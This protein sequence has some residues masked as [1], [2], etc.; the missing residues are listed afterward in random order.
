MKH[1][2]LFAEGR[3]IVSLWIDMSLCFTTATIPSAFN[4]LERH[5]EL[6]KLYAIMAIENNAIL[7]Q[8]RSLVENGIFYGSVA[9][10]R[11]MDHIRNLPRGES[12]VVPPFTLKPSRS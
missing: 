12:N 5:Y 8:R 11:S 4:V 9:R 1:I 7:D 3:D 10:T 6:E 2:R